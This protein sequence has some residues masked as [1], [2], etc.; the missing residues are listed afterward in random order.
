VDGNG[1]VEITDAIL[2]LN[3]LFV[4]GDRPRCMDA[5]DVSDRGTVDISAAINLLGFLFLGGAPPSIPFPNS[6]IDP[7]EDTL[8][9]P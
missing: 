1:N 3:F 5:A 9:C 8:V 4:G 7:T 6:G 2:I